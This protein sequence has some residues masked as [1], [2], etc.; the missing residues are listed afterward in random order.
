MNIKAWGLA[1]L[2]SAIAS[3][4]DAEAQR[5][6]FLWERAPAGCVERAASSCDPSAW[7]DPDQASYYLASLY[8]NGQF[9]LLDD[10]L[11]NILASNARFLNGRSVGTAAAFAFS[12]MLPSTNLD[13]KEI[14]RIAKWRDAVPQSHFTSLAEAY[15]WRRRAWNVRGAGYINTVSTESL[16]LFNKYLRD[17]DRLLQ[18][19][20]EADRNVL[21]YSFSI[22]NSL[23]LDKP[24]GAL[25]DEGMKRWPHFYLLVEEVAPRLQPKWGH[26][27]RDL[28]SFATRWTERLAGT[29]GDSMY[30]RIYIRVRNDAAINETRV[31][32][33]T[34][35]RSFQ[36]LV[37]RYPTPIYKNLFASYACAARDLPTYIEV[38]SALPKDQL[39]P[40]DWNNGHSYEAC[41]RWGSRET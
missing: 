24:T 16:D 15:Y 35:K 3:N 1:A 7:P 14:D 10:A 8:A 21:W 39:R 11:E 23:D 9:K 25:V 34:L 32:W 17:S 6:I 38:M 18:A 29:E 19:I 13:R 36:D 4:V 37:K 12:Y 2:L 30:A 27:W 33:P 40:K 20:P 22:E 41:S 5:F 26:S 28:E 31:D